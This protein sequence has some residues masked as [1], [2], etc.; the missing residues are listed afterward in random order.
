MKRILIVLM[1]LIF[2][3][4][5]S[6]C[7]ETNYQSG[8]DSANGNEEESNENS[9]EILTHEMKKTG[10]YLKETNVV[11]TAK[12]VGASRVDYAQIMVRFYDAEG[13]LLENGMDNAVDIDPGVTFQF[14][15][16][17]PNFE[18]YPDS[19]DIAVEYLDY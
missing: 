5:I 13:I 2:S 1:L 12:N 16:M 3:L 7:T 9:I 15:V 19:Y 6:A 11:G 18:V 4:S 8:S 14:D 10:T 17:F